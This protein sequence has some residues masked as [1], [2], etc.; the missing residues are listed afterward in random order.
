M[1][2]TWSVNIWFCYL[3]K[4][5][6]RYQVF[7]CQ[8]FWAIFQSISMFLDPDW[9]VYGIVV[10]IPTFLSFELANDFHF[11]Q[12][13]QPANYLD[14]H[15]L[16]G[17][18]RPLMDIFYLRL[19]VQLFCFWYFAYKVSPTTLSHFLN[20]VFK[21]FYSRTQNFSELSVRFL[22]ITNFTSFQ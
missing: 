8:I 16:F 12:V 5:H 4:F 2:W 17:L 10:Q 1:F 14:T 3:S 21:N 15:F 6:D 9:H 7:Q 11:L 19:F 13:F 20:F 18:K 22:F